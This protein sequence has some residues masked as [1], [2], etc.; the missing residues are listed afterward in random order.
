MKKSMFSGWNDVFLFTFRQTLVGKGFITVTFGI[1]ALLCAG[2]MI[3]NLVFAMKQDEKV[4]TS[5]VAVVCLVNESGID[6]LDFSMLPQIGGEAYKDV[7]VINATDG[8]DVQ[9]LAKQI[10]SENKKEVILQITKESDA[11]QMSLIIPAESV[12]TK[13]DGNR[14]LD[15][16]VDC[17]E[18][19]KIVA[20]GISS[21]KLIA[22]TSPVT[23]DVREAGEKSEGVGEML[24][25]MLA[26]M[27]FTL[28]LYMMVILYGQSISKT[29][30]AE[31]SSRL[32]ET[33][34]TSVQ[35]YSV[36]A[37]KILAMYAIAV[38]QLFLWI[39]CAVAGFVIGDYA[40]SQL[41][42]DYHNVVM[43]TIDLIRNS[44]TSSAF[45]LSAVVMAAIT[46]LFGFLFYCVIAGCV[47]ANIS[48]AEDLSSG[49]AM[50]QIPVVISFMAAYILPLQE[51]DTLNGFL[52]LIPFTSSFLLPA[53]LVVG[54]I[55][56]V[57]AVLSVFVI[58]LSTLGFII[59]TG[60]IYKNK[61]FY[62][63]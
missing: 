38:F 31:K 54:N 11:F 49:M 36:I 60:K 20:S 33:L 46:I 45:S 40:A 22:I 50:F 25:K 23:T 62:K 27:L 52:Q 35:P 1:A 57:K 12:I 42:P 10:A 17:F 59:L 63:N 51:N 37:G 14:L 53:D 41:S 4:E 32:M 8:N 6:N 56:I 39:I 26:P 2:L 55:S 48:K 47:S 15:Q 18:Q 24:I 44:S 43:D 34:L 7:K 28:L 19:N 3:M 13:E 16:L 30:I 9:S 61:I 21:A 29:V 58:A 5:P